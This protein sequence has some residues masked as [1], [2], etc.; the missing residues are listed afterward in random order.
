MPKQ[1]VLHSAPGLTPCSH[2]QRQGVIAGHEGCNKSK[3]D[4]YHLTGGGVAELM[5]QAVGVRAVE[6]LAPG[7][8]HL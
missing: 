1:R 3:V 4:F 6:H 2:A 7:I 5:P 8:A